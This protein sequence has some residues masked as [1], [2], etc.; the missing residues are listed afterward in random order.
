MSFT[1]MDENTAVSPHPCL[2][3]RP[4]ILVGFTVLLLGLGTVGWLFFPFKDNEPHIAY[5]SWDANDQ[6]QVYLTTLTQVVPTQ[7]TQA[8]GNV[9]SF[10][11]SP[12]AREIVYAVAVDSGGSELWLLSINGCFQPR[13]PQLLLSCPRA[14]CSSPVFAP[15]G[16]R[17]I[18]EKRD[19]T[20]R[21]TLWWLDIETK[22]TVTV[23]RSPD[24]PTFGAQFSPDGNWVSYVTPADESIMLYHFADGRFVT[25]PSQIGIPAAW[26]PTDPLFVTADWN[27]ITYHGENTEE[28]DT[29]THDYSQAINLY[30][31]DLDGSRTPFAH[32][33]N[34]D[35]GNPVWSPEGN[36][37]AFGRKLFQ[38]NTG[39]QIWI[40]GIDGLDTRALTDDLTIHHGALSWSSD[41]R[42]ILHQQYD[43]QQGN[44]RSSIHI[45]QVDTELT[46]QIA[47]LGFL[48]RWVP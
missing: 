1:F 2:S 29:H 48:P 23:L 11:V 22:E 10:A 24:Q 44:G 33:G 14:T 13:T 37:I 34:A 3:K 9:I 36:R 47:P 39:R 32:L 45:I 19:E 27:L 8:A 31:V 43:T 35:D 30:L 15:D 12:T 4:I 41:G 46:Q 20:D 21:P 38:T 5:L 18:Y 7:I 25:I 26:H 16:R 42:Y 6:T 17:L 40:A 28:H